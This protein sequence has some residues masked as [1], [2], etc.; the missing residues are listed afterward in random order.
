[1]QIAPS[2]YFNA[3][4]RQR[5]DH[6]EGLGIWPASPNLRPYVASF[7]KAESK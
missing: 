2:S 6:C 5:T 7:E 1:M 4:S 3:V